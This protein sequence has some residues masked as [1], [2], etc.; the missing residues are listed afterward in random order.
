ML[1]SSD[2]PEGAAG[3]ST[4]AGFTQDDGKIPGFLA[5]VIAGW[6]SDKDLFVLH[7]AQDDEVA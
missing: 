1:H 3:R 5:P 4:A 6:V 7:A 2:D